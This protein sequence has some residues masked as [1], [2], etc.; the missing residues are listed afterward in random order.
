MSRMLKVACPVRAQAHNLKVAGSNPAPATNFYESIYY[1]S[2]RLGRSLC[3]RL[4]SP[5]S[6]TAFLAREELKIRVLVVRIR[7]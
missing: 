3:F 2:V 6:S 4:G 1:N 7:P 5:L